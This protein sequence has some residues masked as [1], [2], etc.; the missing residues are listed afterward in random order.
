MKPETKDAVRKVK[1]AAFIVITVGVM[2]ATLLI[3]LGI[4]VIYKTINFPSNGSSRLTQ[5]YYSFFLLLKQVG[6]IRLV[7]SGIITFIVHYVVYLLISA[8]ATVVANSDRSAVVDALNNINETLKNSN[9][10]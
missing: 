5:A 4:I 7:V 2:M 3:G 8:Y 9:K 6:G 10:N 1:G